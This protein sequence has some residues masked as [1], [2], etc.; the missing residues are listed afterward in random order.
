MMIANNFFSFSKDCYQFDQMRKSVLNIQSGCLIYATN[1]VYEISV[2][3]N[4]LGKNYYQKIRMVLLNTYAP[5]PIV[6][7]K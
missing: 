3:T 5:L 1:R 6:Y 7:L 2:T 4:Y